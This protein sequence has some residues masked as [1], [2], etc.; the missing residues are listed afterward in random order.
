MKIFEDTTIQLKLLYLIYIEASRVNFK[1]SFEVMNWCSHLT[2]PTYKRVQYM[3][4]VKLLFYYCRPLF[5]LGFVVKTSKSFSPF[6]LP[7][8]PLPKTR[9]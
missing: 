6:G 2:V 7:L 3:T 1:E 4:F 9:F 5:P 8:H